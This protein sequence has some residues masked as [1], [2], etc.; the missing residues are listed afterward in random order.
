VFPAKHLTGVVTER[1]AITDELR[2]V[3]VRVEGQI[4]FVPGQY[5]TVG[6]PIGG[7]LIERPYSV[8]SDPREPELEFFL[9]AVPGGKLSPHLSEVPVGGHVFVRPAP[10][11]RFNL[12]TQSG[13]VN[14]FMVAT[15]TG[16]APYVSMVRSLAASRVPR[17]A[18]PCRILILHSASVPAELAY[19]GELSGL[20]QEQPWLRYIPT[21]SRSWLDPEWTGERGRAEDVARKYLDAS[22]FAPPSTTAYLC[23]NPHMI[24]NMEGILQRAGF[25]KESIRR[26]IYWPAD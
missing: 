4:A 26:E 16:V 25:P 14:H 7:K 6:L 11:G 23:G 13:H 15:V 21:I 1:R 17:D 22:E 5:V 12:D 10:K 18:V 2:I 19:R 3:R 9:E 20:A 24:R 8:A